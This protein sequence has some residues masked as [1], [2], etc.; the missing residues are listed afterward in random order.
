[1]P[2]VN[3]A[4]MMG[5]NIDPKS[6]FAGALA[7][8]QGGYATHMA[9][10]GIRD[11]DLAFMANLHKYEQDKANDPLAEAKRQF[12]LEQ[13]TSGNK[14]TEVKQ[15]LDKGSLI[16]EG[17]R[18]SNLS[19]EAR[20]KGEWLAEF[21]Q[22]ADQ[23]LGLDPMKES[24]HAL[25][26]EQVADAGKRGIKLPSWPDASSMDKVKATA[27]AFVNS[28]QVQRKAIEADNQG[29]SNLRY[30]ILPTIAGHASMEQSRD[31][32][33]AA[34]ARETEA[35]RLKGVKYRADALN[36]KTLEA[37]AVENIQKGNVADV[38]ETVEA[39]YLK[40]TQANPTIKLSPLEA[41]Q[42]MAEKKLSLIQRAQGAAVA[43]QPTAAPTPAPAVNKGN[44]TPAEHAKL[45]KGDKYMWNGKE[46]TKE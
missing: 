14:A 36:P 10:Q 21:A 44:I 3:P 37:F 7:G 8:V 5:G 39:L 24:D 42:W 13:Y 38:D 15:G 43:A 18:Q 12:E 40:W 1:M 41:Q 34:R 27:A 29:A 23:Y 33:A 31:E 11:D 32:R 16:N 22:H 26:Q 19:E 46:Y 17:L 4:T 45:K 2:Y 20:Q 28:A 30:N 6:P 25:W 9:D 35:S